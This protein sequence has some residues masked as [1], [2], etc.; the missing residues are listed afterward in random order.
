MTDR[1]A[2]VSWTGDATGIV[3]VVASG[4]AGA[5]GAVLVVAGIAVFVSENWMVVGSVGSGPALA[6]GV[7]NS[8]TVPTG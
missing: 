8:T 7:A 2:F 5:G 1:L 6:V 4:P 3:V